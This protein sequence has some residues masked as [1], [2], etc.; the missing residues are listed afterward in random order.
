MQLVTRRWIMVIAL[1]LVVAFCVLSV[2]Q[3]IMRRHFRLAVERHRKITSDVHSLSAELD[4][5]KAANGSYPTTEQGL[6]VLRVRPRDPWDHD[7]IY[8]SPG[9]P[10]HD[11]YD[12]FSAGPDWKPNTLDDDWGD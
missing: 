4:R 11:P 1:F 12:V 10:H 9:I 8:R 2:P 3:I 5:Y 7:Y 6:R